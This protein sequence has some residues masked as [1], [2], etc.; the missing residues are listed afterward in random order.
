MKRVIVAVA[1]PEYTPLLEVA[2]PSFVRFATQYG[3]DLQ[4]HTGLAAPPGRAHAWNKLPFLVTALQDQ[5]YDQVLLLDTDI[6]IVKFDRDFPWAE[7]GGADHALYVE[8]MPDGGVCPN[9]GVWGVTKKTLPLL[10]NIWAYPDRHDGE[11]ATKPCWEQ[12]AYMAL[13]GYNASVIPH[14][15]PAKFP[16]NLYDIGID[17]NCPHVYTEKDPIIWHAGGMPDIEMRRQ[18]MLKW[19]GRPY[20]R[21][22]EKGIEWRI[23]N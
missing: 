14:T 20:E 7:M 17:W 21:M 16:S 3:Y 18:L 9:T 23:K 10:Y 13:Q 12:S 19:S 15:A 2:Q 4:L 1:S 11:W 5:G 6:V 8:D 22:L